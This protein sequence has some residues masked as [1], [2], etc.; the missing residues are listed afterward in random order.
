M[1]QL[2]QHASSHMFVPSPQFHE[3]R[4]DGPPVHDSGPQSE[5]A[6][7]TSPSQSSSR[8]LLHRSPAPGFT[9]ASLGAQ[10]LPGIPLQPAP[11]T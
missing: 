10:S 5:S 7:S 8:P 9:A 1:G 3:V 2:M 6:L 4:H 11:G